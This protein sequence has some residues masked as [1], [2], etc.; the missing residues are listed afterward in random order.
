MELGP[1][2]ILVN[3]VSPGFVDTQMTRRNN[4][5]LSI[6][7]FEEA[8]PLGKLG[9]PAD[10]ARASLFLC[11]EENTYITGHNLVVDGGFSSGRFQK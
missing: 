1:H 7:R 10:I 3:A 6:A 4:D 8:I 5:A 9:K 11:S 2:C